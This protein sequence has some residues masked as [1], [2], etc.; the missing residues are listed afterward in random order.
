MASWQP[1]SGSPWYGVDDALLRRL[2][3]HETQVHALEPGRELV[4]LGDSLALFDST[5]PDPFFNRIG[6]IRW[7]HEPVAFE[8]SLASALRLFEERRRQPYLWLSPGFLSPPDLP[9]RLHGHGFVEV[10]DGALMMILVDDPRPRPRRPL[11]VGASLERLTDHGLDGGRAGA[12]AAAVVVAEAFGVSADRIGP[13]TDRIAFGI[14]DPAQDIR[15]VRVDG[16]PAA[17]G[18]RND[19]DG[20]SY[21]SAIGTRRAFQGRGLAEAITRALVEEALE[22][23]I[24]H[25]YLGTYG[26]NAAALTVYRRV[27]FAVIGGPALELLRP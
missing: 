2:E 4:D 8:S 13:L 23:G 24:E 11:A 1:R 25:I 12:R 17:V 27:G 22:L 16:E 9:D 6:A 19:R 20:M 10:G 3:I 26:D 7:P 18:R 21:L 14:G 5:D 15:L